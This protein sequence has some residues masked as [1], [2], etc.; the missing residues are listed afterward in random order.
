ML[1]LPQVVLKAEAAGGL[2]RLGDLLVEDSW[3]QLLGPQLAS[4]GFA[5]LEAFVRSEWGG[6]QMVFPPKD[7]VF[8]WV[9]GWVGGMLVCLTAHIG[10]FDVARLLAVS[11]CRQAELPPRL[12]CL[13]LPGRLYS[14]L[15]QL[16]N[17]SGPDT[18]VPLPSPP[19][20][21]PTHLCCRALNSVP[22][23]KVRVV[24][25]GQDPYHDLGQAMGLSFSVPQASTAG[26]A[27]AASGY[28]RQCLPAWL[29]DL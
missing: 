14:L 2:P 7:C 3:R 19:T 20:P 25:L 9:G 4:P 28:S 18:W 27:A 6:S 23:G 29:R 24:I 26:A 11:S 22:V 17:W 15:A 8:R 12:C 5:D 10:G 13:W 21:P 1:S 16:A